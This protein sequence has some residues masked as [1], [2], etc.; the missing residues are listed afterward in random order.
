MSG[1]SEKKE[2]PD[3]K[4]GVQDPL[5]VYKLCPEHVRHETTMFMAETEE[6]KQNVQMMQPIDV[7]EDEFDGEDE[8][9]NEPRTSQ[10]IVSTQR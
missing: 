4:Y 5:H 8:I 3:R 6:A 1:T 10:R 9:C 7:E 2:D